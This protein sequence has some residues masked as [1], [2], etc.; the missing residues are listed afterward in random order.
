MRV[1]VLLSPNALVISNSPMSMAMRDRKELQEV[2]SK[3]KKGR[4]LLFEYYYYL[5][6][7]PYSVRKTVIYDA[8][9]LLPPPSKMC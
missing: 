4:A 7:G 6:S 1:R 5:V 8:N 2:L 9:A 3:S